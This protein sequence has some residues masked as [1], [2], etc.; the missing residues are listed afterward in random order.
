MSDDDLVSRHLR[1][2]PPMDPREPESGSIPEAGLLGR[3]VDRLGLVFAA[4][5]VAAAGVLLLEVVLR[6]LLASPTIWAHETAIFLCAV[7]FIYGGLFCA[8]KDRHIRVVLL[9]DLV[10][11][12]ARRLLDLVLSLVCAGSAGFF[13]Y[14]AWLMVERAIMR[15][16]GEFRLETSGSA[17]NPPTPALLKVFLMVVM[18]LLALQFL[19][20]AFNY[21]R[22]T[23]SKGRR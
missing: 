16:T 4:G 19:V 12:R 23:A 18:A 9:Y 2:E 13:T 8:A 15:P 20:L 17:W 21:A 11:G 3:A 5:L 7:G 1:A 6:Y 22:G 10:G 14:A